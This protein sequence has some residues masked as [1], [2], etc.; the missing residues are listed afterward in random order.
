MVIIIILI[1]SIVYTIQV[2]KQSLFFLNNWEKQLNDG[3][4]NK[5]QFLT[6]TTAESLRL[7]LQSTIDLTNY[8]LEECNFHYVLTVK[9]NRD[10]LEVSVRKFRNMPTS[11]MIN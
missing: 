8:L 9:F 10:S 2:L 7:T 6:K 3:Y 11:Y 4:L 5:K 1:K